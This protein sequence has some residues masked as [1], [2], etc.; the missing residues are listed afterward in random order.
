MATDHVESGS[1]SQEPRDVHDVLVAEACVAES[2]TVRD[3]CSGIVDT[4]C[5][6]SVSGDAWYLNYKSR[7]QTLGLDSEVTE[8]PE[9]ENIGLET[10]ESCEVSSGQQCRLF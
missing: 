5:K 2:S 3:S 9:K 10:E 6:I 8:T 4:A 1:S 7:L